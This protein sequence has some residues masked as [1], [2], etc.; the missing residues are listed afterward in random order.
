[1]F[2][3]A[4]GCTIPLLKLNVRLARIH[5]RWR[6]P[7]TYAAWGVTRILGYI[8]FSLCKKLA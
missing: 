8:A 6:D 5:E 7:L 3:V 1:M 4:M 2:K